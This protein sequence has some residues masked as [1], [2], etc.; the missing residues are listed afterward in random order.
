MEWLNAVSD[1]AYDE[2]QVINDWEVLYFDLC[3]TSFF[4]I[5]SFM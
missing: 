4:K 2:L 3:S 1:E 5:R